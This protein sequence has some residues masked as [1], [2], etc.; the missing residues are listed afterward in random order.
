MEIVRWATSSA[1]FAGKSTT[2]SVLPAG[3]FESWAPET[4]TIC[5]AFQ[6]ERRYWRLARPDTPSVRRSREGDQ[7]SDTIRR[8]SELAPRKGKGEW[9]V[10]TKTPRRQ[11]RNEVGGVDRGRRTERGRPE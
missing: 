9:E 4:K 11:M 10:S 7:V 1:P 3:P 5:E 8:P 6:A 2:R